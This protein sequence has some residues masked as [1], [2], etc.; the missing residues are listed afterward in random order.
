M[1]SARILAKELVQTKR[2]VSQLYANRAHIMATSVALSEQLAVV[3]TSGTLKR[4]NQI[5]EAMS[6]L[7]KIPEMMK[8]SQDLARGL[9]ESTNCCGNVF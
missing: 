8:I 1:S 4:S 6:K 3:R 2:V 9:F 5:M 7:L